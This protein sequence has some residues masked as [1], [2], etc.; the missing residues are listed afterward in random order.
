MKRGVAAPSYANQP[1]W[2]QCSPVLRM[3]RRGE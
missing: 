3:I 1:L 2:R